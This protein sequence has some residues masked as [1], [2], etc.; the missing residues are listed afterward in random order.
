MEDFSNYLV[1]N[2]KQIINY[3]KTLAKE[4]CLI[5]AG[6]GDNNSFLTAI[7]EINEKSQTIIIDCGPK[8]YLNREL[9][10]VGLVNC[11]ADFNGIKVLFK[12]RRVKKAGNPSAP[13][14]SIQIP[15]LLY[16]VQRRKFYRVRSPLS[17]N[18]YCTIHL[19]ETASEAK[20]VLNFLTLVFLDFHLLWKI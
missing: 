19:Q 6:F 7:L 11:T 1:K 5:A 10:S 13:A 14:L 12:G 16:W 9:L 2:P 17:K 20:K 15:E 8:E 4:K 3:L 18:S